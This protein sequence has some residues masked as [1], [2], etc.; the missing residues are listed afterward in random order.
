MY[1][2]NTNYPTTVDAAAYSIFP[3]ALRSVSSVGGSISTRGTSSVGGSISTRRASSPEP[4]DSVSTTRCSPRVIDMGGCGLS[5]LLPLLLLLLLFVLHHPLGTLLRHSHHF[6]QNSYS[7]QQSF[8]WKRN[9]LWW[10]LNS[11]LLAQRP[12]SYHYTKAESINFLSISL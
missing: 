7:C 9:C 12:A 4:I 6:G 11:G 2:L 3:E 1:S 8:P 5:L 10:E